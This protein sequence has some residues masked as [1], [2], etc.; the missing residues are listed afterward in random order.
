[1]SHNPLRHRCTADVVQINGL[2][3]L[4]FVALI[5]AILSLSAC[6]SHGKQSEIL[7][8]ANFTDI[9]KK[10]VSIA[11]LGGTG[12]VGSFIL[13]QALQR[14]YDVRVLARTPS[15][16]KALNGYITIIEG[17][18][19]NPI[20]IDTLLRGSNIVISALGPVKTDGSAAKLLSTTATGLV[21][22]SMLAHNI[23][24]YIVVS[25]AAVEMPDDDRNM[26]GWLVEQSA[27]L[28][29]H[30][31]LADKQSEYQVLANST[32]A[33]TLVRCPIIEPEAYLR[34]PIASLTTPISF[35]LRA[36][37]LASFVL[38]QIDSTTF[39]RKGP[40]LSSQ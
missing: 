13:V 25:G 21:T 29:L 2:K 12:M 33:W 26:T 40:F 11:L 28:A 24:R 18:A 1:M 7:P 19:R 14:G 23:Q 17:D 27:S 20:A 16:L 8:P 3:V 35:Y 39:I 9:V 32:L 15:K 10:D 6:I 22:Q 30:D 36:G 4:S 37:E 5:T 31:T 34:A 38:D